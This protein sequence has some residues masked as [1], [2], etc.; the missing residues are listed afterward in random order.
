MRLLFFLFGAGERAAGPA[1]RDGSEGGTGPAESSVLG[2]E[3]G[4]GLGDRAVPGYAALPS[5]CPESRSVPTAIGPTAAGFRRSPVPM[6]RLAP[7]DTGLAKVEMCPGS[8]PSWR[9]PRSVPGR[10]RSAG[11]SPCPCAQA[12]GAGTAARPRLHSTGAFPGRPSLHVHSQPARSRLRGDTHI[13]V[14]L[15]GTP[16][17]QAVTAQSTNSGL[18]PHDNQVLLC[19]YTHRLL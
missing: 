13:S 2:T 15:L 3:L 4:T 17:P 6:P 8:I 9:Q 1:E 10:P 14:P 5:R 19:F 16:V 7:G 12:R 11:L 18:N